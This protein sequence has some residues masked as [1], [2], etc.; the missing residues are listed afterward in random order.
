[1]QSENCLCAIC[2]SSVVMTFIHHENVFHEL[3]GCFFTASCGRCGDLPLESVIHNG[4]PVKFSSVPDWRQYWVSRGVSIEE[5]G[6][7]K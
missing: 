6:Y 3:T 5:V 7:A 4:Y 2:G 1:M